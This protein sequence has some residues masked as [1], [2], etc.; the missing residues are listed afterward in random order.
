MRQLSLYAIFCASL[1]S[2]MLY[3]GVCDCDKG[4]R[5]I[6]CEISDE[7]W[8]IESKAEV[9]SSKID[10]IHLD[11]IVSFSGDLSTVESKLDK[12]I[13][14]DWSIES[15]AEVISSKI[16]ILI[17]AND[18]GAIP[19]TNLNAT[20]TISNPGH[21]CLAEDIYTDAAANA[22]I[23]I[24]A[25]DVVIDFNG[26][27]AYGIVLIRGIVA[28]VASFEHIVFENG[29]IDADVPNVGQADY[30]VNVSNATTNHGSNLTLSNMKLRN[31]GIAALNVPID[32]E[33]EELTVKNSIFT[34]YGD[35]GIY[36]TYGEA[37]RISD[38][39]FWGN[40]D[41]L[42]ATGFAMFDGSGFDIR[43]SVFQFNSAGI[44]GDGVHAGHIE[45]DFL[46]NNNDIGLYLV[47]SQAVDIENVEVSK[48]K[49][50]D[51]PDT[52]VRTGNGFA[53]SGGHAVSF[54]NCFSA[55]YDHGYDM[56]NTTTQFTF[57]ACTARENI[58]GFVFAP[59]VTGFVQG[60][61]AIAN[62]QGS[63]GAGFW[64]QAPG[65]N[66]PT[67]GDS[68][69]AVKYAVNVAQGNG[70]SPVTNTGTNYEIYI[71]ATATNVNTPP[72][73]WKQMSSSPTYWNNANADL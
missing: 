22:V 35:Y 46:V 52:E 57:F 50:G 25:N 40:E 3:A 2:G 23:S 58:Y 1:F 39:L 45:G 36:L 73:T 34:G 13:G 18:C 5:Q 61:M 41:V 68:T 33:V 48:A 54:S 64:D 14:E 60:C 49:H 59:G 9:I 44:Y 32:T 47:D 20:V 31:A 30:C 72:Y 63:L 6:V 43:N 70:S 42:T 37:I 21:Y 4:V 71:P 53:I 56:S 65:K 62:K 51:S 66:G 16:D 24:E 19:I 17:N 55:G 38:S 26:H 28:Q 15:K 69:S 29:V 10:N 12:I 11:C 67:S 27:V 8:S 7:A